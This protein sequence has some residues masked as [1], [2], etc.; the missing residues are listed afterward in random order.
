MTV[1]SHRCGSRVAVVFDVD[2]TL[3]DSE[4]FGHRVAFNRA[5]TELGMNV[6]WDVE[7]YSSLLS[8]TGGQRRI[9]QYLLQSGWSAKEAA[10]DAARAHR[11]KTDLFVDL[12]LSGRIPPRPGVRRL[13]RRL[14]GAGVELHVASTGRAQWVRPLLS[15]TFG[16]DT[17]DIVVTG[18]DVLELKPAPEAYRNV[19][20]A[21]G[22]DPGHLV[23]VEDSLNGVMSASSA[24][25]PC[26]VVTNVHGDAG[27]FPGAGLVCAGFEELSAERL[28]GL[29]RCQN[30]SRSLTGMMPRSS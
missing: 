7:C 24:G 26:A 4:P 1:R 21:T 30:A 22:L 5:F 16:S 13:L 12:A 10:E 3:F 2:G 14:A 20:A 23:A 8:T 18:D 6:H 19:M 29:M 27:P 28:L 17:F 15:S 25:L 11:R 9:Q